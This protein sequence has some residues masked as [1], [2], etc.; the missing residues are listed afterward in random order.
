[1]SGKRKSIIWSLS[2]KDI[3]SILSQSNTLVEALKKIGVPNLTAGYSIIKKRI[4][5][6]ELDVRHIVFGLDSNKS[7]KFEKRKYPSSN[8]EVFVRNSK[9]GKQTL[10]RRVLKE[11]VL[12]Y[13]CIS[14]GN[15]GKWNDKELSLHLDH[16]NGINNDNRKENLRFLCPNCH[17]QTE[18]FGAYNTKK[19]RSK[20]DGRCE[21]S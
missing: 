2:K 7:R 18:T 6:D 17:S 4:K 5:E 11:G 9:V 8:E 10:K 15:N 14:C 21:K 13:K 12:K 20:S 1:M 16:I 19:Y 3:Q